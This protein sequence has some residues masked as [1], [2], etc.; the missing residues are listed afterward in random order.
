[1]PSLPPPL[2]S[3]DPITT[4]APWSAKI[5]AYHGAIT[6][7]PS[8]SVSIQ[9]LANGTT[10]RASATNPRNSPVAAEVPLNQFKVTVVPNPGGTE[11]KDWLVTVLGG[12]AQAMFGT[13]TSVVGVNDAAVAIESG[14]RAF[15]S[16]VYRIMDDGEYVH[17]FDA[18]IDIQVGTSAPQSTASLAYFP[19]AAVE[20]DGTVLQGHL[21]AVYLASPM[22]VVDVEDGEE[23]ENA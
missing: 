8:A 3:G 7:R 12:T 19:V 17:E 4:I 22:N 11:G 10:F 6:P 9:T 16:L 23:E 18:A 13:I 20:A 15:V 5:I 1:M 2:R 14:K 21:G